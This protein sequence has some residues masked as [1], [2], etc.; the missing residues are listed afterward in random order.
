ML[1][2]YLYQQAVLQRFAGECLGVGQLNELL[3]AITQFYIDRGYVTSRAYLPQQDLSSGELR[4]IVVEG[5]LEGLDSSTLAS[6]RE[7]A[8]G[9]PGQPGDVLD[10][11]ELE[12]LVEQRT[13]ALV[14]AHTFA[15]RIWSYQMFYTTA[16]ALYQFAVLGVRHLLP[17][18]FAMLIALSVVMAR[19]SR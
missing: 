8:M 9:F 4:V 6:D 2:S 10:L 1:Q 12:Q 14:L 15:S 16:V 3:K 5:R 13:R 19:R 17:A 18:G 11:R 7:L